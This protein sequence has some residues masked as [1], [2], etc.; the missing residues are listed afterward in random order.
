MSTSDL[1]FGQHAGSLLYL[2]IAGACL[3]LALHLIKR[4]VAPIG[5][6]VQAAAALAAG[7]LAVGAALVLIAAA[8]VG[9]F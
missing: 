2:V 9:G 1:A 8:L 7:G 3:L 6:L 5:A 4:A